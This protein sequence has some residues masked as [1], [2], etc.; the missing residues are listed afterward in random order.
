MSPSD[1]VRH[2]TGLPHH[3]ELISERAQH[4]EEELSRAEEGPRVL[5]AALN[6]SRRVALMSVSVD[7]EA[8]ERGTWEAWVAWMQVAESVLA[9]SRAAEGSTVTRRVHHRIREWPPRSR[10]PPPPPGAGSRLS[11][12]R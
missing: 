6:S 11:S 3:P 1:I 8:R 7:P 2:D 10:A 12:S 5:Y 9:T 4:R